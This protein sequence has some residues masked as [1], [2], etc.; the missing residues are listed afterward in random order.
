SSGSVEL[1]GVNAKSARRTVGMISPSIALLEDRSIYDNIALPL[2]LARLSKVRVSEAVDSVI[3][4]FNLESVRLE[5]PSAVSSGLKQ[6][7]AIARA[8]VSEPFSLVA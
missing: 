1:N 7:A 4:R 5:A 2:E 8:V 3:R 6:K